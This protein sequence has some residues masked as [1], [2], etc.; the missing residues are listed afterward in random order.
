MNLDHRNNMASTL[1]SDQQM[2]GMS[3]WISGQECVMVLSK[4]VKD[5]RDWKRELRRTPKLSIE[6]I[7][8]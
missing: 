2:R 5:T 3:F 6:K 7:L 4:N 1:D 8:I